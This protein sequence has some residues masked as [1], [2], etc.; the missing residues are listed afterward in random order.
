MGSPS[1]S[2]RTL[3]SSFATLDIFASPPVDPEI[4]ALV[5][6][7]ISISFPILRG[8]QIARFAR[9]LLLGRVFCDRDFLG[10]FF[11]SARARYRDTFDF[12]RV[13]APPALA[14]FYDLPALVPARSYMDDEQDMGYLWFREEG[15]TL[16]DSNITFPVNLGFLQFFSLPLLPPGWRLYFEELSDACALYLFA[17]AASFVS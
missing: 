16:H 5:D 12:D 8:E 11:I 17:V 10:W 6:A 3:V 13:E 1:E 14:D 9:P 4:T 15:V 2:V 7:C